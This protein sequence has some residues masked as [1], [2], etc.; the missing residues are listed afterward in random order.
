[1]RFSPL[2]LLV[3]A[4]L[5]GTLC[6]QAA[7]VAVALEW[8]HGTAFSTLEGERFLGLVAFLYAPILAAAMGF[9]AFLSAHLITRRGGDL[10]LGSAVAFASLAA[11]AAALATFL[12]YLLF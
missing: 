2:A 5:F 9:L 7:Y 3:A 1:M 8:V 12:L 10:S 11:V 6:G 4:I